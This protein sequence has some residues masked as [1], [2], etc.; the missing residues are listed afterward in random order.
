MTK[1]TIIRQPFES[2]FQS[3]SNQCINTAWP[4]CGRPRKTHLTTISA[5]MMIVTCEISK[6]DHAEQ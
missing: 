4:P 5:I 1:V 6:S 2:S 3:Q